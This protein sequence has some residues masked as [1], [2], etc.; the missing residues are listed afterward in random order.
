MT[1]FTWDILPAPFIGGQSCSDLPIR[2]C[3]YPSYGI[4]LLNN[5]APG[6]MIASYVWDQDS[7][8]LGAYM[9]T[10]SALETLMSITLND[11]ASMNNISLSFLE[12]QYFAYHAWDWYHNEW[13]VGHSPCSDQINSRKCSADVND[14]CAGMTFALCRRG[15][16]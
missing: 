12:D 1:L 5:T 4:N 15:V 8:R 6:T 2:R 9:Q 10:P 14:A 3:V 16:E 13:S 11:L 7:S